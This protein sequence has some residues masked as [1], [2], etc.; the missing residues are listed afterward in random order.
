MTYFESEYMEEATLHCIYLFYLISL[1]HHNGQIQGSCSICIVLHY[2]GVISRI[3]TVLQF[4]ALRH[5]LHNKNK[6]IGPRTT[7]LQVA[8]HQLD[9]EGKENKLLHV[10][11]K[12]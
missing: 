8:S 9:M 10:N 5:S 3:V 2:G 4:P 7:T 6:S 12:Q 11:T 1:K